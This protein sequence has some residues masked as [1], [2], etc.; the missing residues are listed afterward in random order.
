MCARNYDESITFF[1]LPTADPSECFQGGTSYPLSKSERD[2]EYALGW[3]LLK[4]FE[5]GVRI[6]KGITA[7]AGAES[8]TVFKELF[9]RTLI[10]FLVES[11][12][13]EGDSFIG[14]GHAM[15]TATSRAVLQAAYVGILNRLKDT[16]SIDDYSIVVVPNADGVLNAVDVAF[17]V[18]VGHEINQIFGY[19]TVGG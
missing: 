13:R 14:S 17:S 7:Q 4:P 9:V 3:T 8:P 1:P 16:Q 10:D 5:E 12:E 18:D 6:T 11:L 2:A 15:Q 19:M